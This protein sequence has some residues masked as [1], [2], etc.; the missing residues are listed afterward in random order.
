MS[1]RKIYINSDV[2]SEAKKR[3]ELIFDEFENVVVSVSG[4]KDSTVLFE[5][6]RLEAIK[7][8]RKLNL[9]FIDQ[10]AEYASTIE[11]IEYMMS[12]KGVNPYWYQVPLYM[13]NSTSYK[14]HL[15]YAW[16]D[17]DVWMRDKSNLAIH[18]IDCKYPNRFYT[19][20]RWFEDQF[21]TNTCH[22]V[23]L[24]GEESLNRLRAVIKNPGY[25]NY[26]WTTKT[27]N[28]ITAYPLYDWTFEDVWYHISINNIK[29]NKLYDFLY[30]RGFNIKEARVSNL[31]HEKSFS[32][33]TYL[34]EFEP[35]TYEKLLKR[36]DGI[37]VA[38]RYAKE[39]MIFNNKILPK[40]FKTWIEY[41]DFLLTTVV[42]SDKKLKLMNRFKSYDNTEYIARQQVKQ[43]LIFDWEN[44]IPV[45]KQKDNNSKLAYWREV[46]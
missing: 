4:G 33:L 14:D 39:S 30:A 25:K 21:D 6:A 23:G 31:I 26:N 46:L 45:K 5:L 20:I 19:F 8:N 38:A 32:C 7:R 28:H 13:T 27:K 11:M 43:I 15:L 36:L 40:N 18:S 29:Y 44:N 22:L 3:I 16:G 35:E 34:Q 12:Q 17:K 9:F 2:L 42:E 24:R 37:H 1:G 41:R 10:E